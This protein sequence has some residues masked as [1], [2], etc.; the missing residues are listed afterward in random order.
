MS[1]KSYFLEVAY[2]GARYSGSQRQCNALTVEAVLQR[3][4]ATYL[5]FSSFAIV[6]SSRTDA[7]VHARAN[8]FQLKWEGDKTLT[9]EDIPHLN[10]LLPQDVAIRRLQAVPFTAHPRFD[11]LRRQYRY[12]LI[13]SK[14]PFLQ[15]TA[16]HYPK[17][18]DIEYLNELA[19]VVKKHRNFTSFS[20]KHTQTFTNDCKIERCIWHQSEEGVVYFEVS[21]QRF[22]RGMVRALVATML[23]AARGALSREDFMELFER[24]E[25]A[26]ADFSAPPHGLMLMKVD[27][28][29]F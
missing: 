15:T 13:A 7:G 23:K 4:V 11:A 27:Y 8:V 10:A 5:R 9:T 20:K 16:W 22:L 21:A 24:P 26:R 28:D 25:I 17:K 12:T 29:Y 3:A 1:K 6:A 2:I 18:I 19:C 14:N